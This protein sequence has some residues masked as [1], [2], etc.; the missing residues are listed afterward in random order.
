MLAL[1]G[2]KGLAEAQPEIIDAYLMSNLEDKNFIYGQSDLN[3]VF[4]IRDEAM[5]KVELGKIRKALR[6]SWPANFLIDLQRLPVLKESE[7]KT[8][9]IRSH[10][11]TST[12]GG[13]VTW[14]SILSGEKTSFN[15]GRQGYFSKH[16]FYLQRLEHYLLKDLR[17]RP[18]SKH[19][20]RSY[21]KNVT[22]AL[23]GMARDGLLPKI[24]DEKWTKQSQKL[25]GF[26]P[27]ARFY[28]NTHKER[29]WRILDFGNKTFETVEDNTSIYPERLLE[30]CDELCS[31]KIVEDVLITPSLLQN[32]ERARGKAFVEVLLGGTEKEINKKDVKAVQN[33]IDDFLDLQSQDEE[34]ELKYEFTLSTSGLMSLRHLRGLFPYPLEG[35]Y[36]REKAFSAKGRLYEFKANDQHLEH[37]LIH[38]LLLEFMRFRSQ[39]LSTSLIGSKFVKSLNLMNRYILIID[40]LQGREL[41]IPERFSDMMARITPQLGHYRSE[42]PVEEEDWPL[43]KSQLVYSLKKIRDELSKKKPTLKNLQF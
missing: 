26:S 18:V 13:T 2:A 40:Y 4:I 17:S 31:Y 34:P 15:A 42:M 24:K 20:I 16:Y 39:K 9:L 27:F 10:L 12:T 5:P 1:K 32:T 43:I 21:G 25:F 30:F 36:R 8:P 38:F 7:F 19:Y 22:R 28:F 41:A 29:T 35:W 23:E 11:V 6:Q 33:A 14:K 37:A 3:L